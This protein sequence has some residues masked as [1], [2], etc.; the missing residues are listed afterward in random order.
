[1]TKIETVDYYEGYRKALIDF[2]KWLT[3]GESGLISARLNHAKGI[4][5]SLACI[6][7]NQ[8]TFMQQQESFT[9]YFIRDGKKW[10]YSETPPDTNQT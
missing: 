4:L 5:G 10:I 6:L 2:H 8:D 1:M 7:E 3:V 9:V